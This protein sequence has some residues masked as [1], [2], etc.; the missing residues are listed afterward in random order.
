VNRPAEEHMAR[1]A[2]AP[3]LAVRRL[4]ATSGAAG[5]FIRLL[6][7]PFRMYREDAARRERQ[8]LPSVPALDWQ[9]AR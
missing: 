2:F 1:A 5:W 6:T 3:S 9:D 4:L 8:A 7:H